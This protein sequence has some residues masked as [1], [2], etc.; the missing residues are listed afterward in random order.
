MNFLIGDTITQHPLIF[1][2]IFDSAHFWGSRKYP[3]LRA[4]LFWHIGNLL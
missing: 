4:W 1:K 2:L 3:E